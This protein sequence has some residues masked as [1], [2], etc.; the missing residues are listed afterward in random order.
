MRRIPDRACAQD[1]LIDQ[2]ATLSGLS[3]RDVAHDGPCSI[4]GLQ[5]F[6]RMRSMRT[7]MAGSIAVLP[8]GLYCRGMMVCVPVDFGAGR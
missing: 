4:L 5:A 2:D 6:K 1:S 7:R 8:D 3:F